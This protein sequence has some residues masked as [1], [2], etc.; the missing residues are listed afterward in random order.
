MQHSTFKPDTH[1]PFERPVQN[2]PF[3]RAVQTARSD[4][5]FERVMCIGLYTRVAAY[6]YKLNLVRLW[7]NKLEARLTRS[8]NSQDTL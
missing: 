6:S 4:G 2:G 8:C 7:Y 5:S 3:E 1:Y